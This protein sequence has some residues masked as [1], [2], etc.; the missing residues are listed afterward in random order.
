MKFIYIFSE[1]HSTDFID[2]IYLFVI[3]VNENFFIKIVFL[4]LIIAQKCQGIELTSSYK[5][6]RKQKGALAPLDLIIV[7]S[8]KVPII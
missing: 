2:I 7:P 8:L 5:G 4:N 1:I 6:G 3:M